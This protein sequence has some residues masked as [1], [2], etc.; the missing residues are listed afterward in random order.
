MANNNESTARTFLVVFVLCLVCSIFV[1]GITV[2]LRGTQDKA[3]ALDKQANIVLVSGLKFDIDKDDVGAIY[4]SNIVGKFVDIKNSKVLSKDEE[5]KFLESQK[6]KSVFEFDYVAASKSGELSKSIEN[7]VAGIRT[8][9]EVMPV[10][11]AKENGKVVSYILPFY[12]QGLWSTLYGYLAI[13]PDGKKVIGINFYEHGETPG[14]GG[15]ISNPLW[16]AK[17]VNKDIFLDGKIIEVVKGQASKSNQIDGISGATLT[18][19]G[20]T[21]CMQY[22]LSDDAYGSLLKNSA[23]LSALGGE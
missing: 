17:W 19:K 3:K 10:F 23:I 14:L 12:G 2:A 9:S 22:W 4:N 11:V 7:D 6:I 5:A 18:G 15:E 21:N 13:S 20:V 16:T 1:A 8:R